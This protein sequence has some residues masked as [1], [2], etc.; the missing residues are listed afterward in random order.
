[1]KIEMEK[2]VYPVSEFRVEAD[3]DGKPKKIVGYAARF[4][5]LSED[6]GGFREKIAPGA[7]AKTIQSAD[8]R[9]LMNHDPNY[10]FGRTTSGTLRLSETRMGL[11]IEADPPDTQWFRDLATSIDR[12]DIDQM[13]FGFNTIAD[14]WETKGRGEQEQNI[15]TLEEVELH[16]ISV[17]T[18]PAYPQTEVAIRNLEKHKAE[19]IHEET[20]KIDDKPIPDSAIAESESEDREGAITPVSILNKR[21]KLKERELNP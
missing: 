3:E 1:M 9:G 14:S 20:K 15:R 18:F 2:R 11:K 6:L 8:V 5:K 7:F 4:N 13:S 21:L 17:V 12:G 19:N 10:V 16:D